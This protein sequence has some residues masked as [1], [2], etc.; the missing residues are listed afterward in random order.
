[1]DRVTDISV[2]RW[3][4]QIS[5]KKNPEV[6]KFRLSAINRKIREAKRMFILPHGTWKDNIRSVNLDRMQRSSGRSNEEERSAGLSSEGRD[7][8]ISQAD[9]SAPR[10]CSPTVAQLHKKGSRHRRKICAE[11]FWLYSYYI[12]SS[13]SNNKNINYI[14]TFLRVFRCLSSGPICDNCSCNT[15]KISWTIYL[16]YSHQLRLFFLHKYFWLLPRHCDP[17]RT[18]KE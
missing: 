13:P 10:V 3:D 12:Q 17:V 15:S 11:Y 9:L 8:L 6:C 1:M 5:G 2:R 18:R 4:Q 14:F 7:P 16:L